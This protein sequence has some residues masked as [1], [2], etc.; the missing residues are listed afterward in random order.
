MI[1]FNDEKIPS[2]VMPVMWKG[3]RKTPTTGWRTSAS[4]ANGQQKK[5][6]INH[7]MNFVIVKSPRSPHITLT[8]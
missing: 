7:S 6:R 3:R 5:S 4:D 2:I 1:D 8:R